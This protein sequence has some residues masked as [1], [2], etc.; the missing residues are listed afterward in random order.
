MIPLKILYFI[1]LVR[2]L[3]KLF[4]D[5][6]ISGLKIILSDFCFMGNHQKTVEFVISFHEINQKKIRKRIG[7]FQQ[8]FTILYLSSRND[9]I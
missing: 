8:I 1:V 3:K 5:F 4:R 9:M 6:S 7:S 2:M